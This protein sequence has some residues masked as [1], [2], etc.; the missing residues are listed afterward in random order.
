M[1]SVR[2]KTFVDFNVYFGLVDFPMQ[3]TS[4][5]QS[6]HGGL[7]GYS[8]PHVS[9]MAH[10]GQFTFYKLN[11]NSKLGIIQFRSKLW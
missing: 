10:M 7:L 8:T 5:L 1:S 2:T 11:V 9:E 3:G 4:K 6:K